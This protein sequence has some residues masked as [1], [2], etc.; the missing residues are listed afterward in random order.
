MQATVGV[1]QAELASDLFALVVFL[2]KNCNSD[3]LAALGQSELTLTQVKLLHQMENADREFTLKDAAELVNVSL[4]AASRTVDDLVRRGFVLRHEDLT[5]RRMK[6]VS[7]TDT[8]RSVILRINA[9]RLHGLE[10]FAASLSDTERDALS[11]ALAEL[12]QRD[13]I[14]ACRPTGDQT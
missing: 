2:N 4:P 10:Q 3:L 13:G 8:G 5:D 9:A 12:L 7:L 11:A 6:R 1:S 14:A